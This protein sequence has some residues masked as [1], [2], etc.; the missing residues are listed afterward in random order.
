MSLVACITGL[1]PP[2]LNSGATLSVFA[3]TALA[4]ASIAIV[5]IVWVGVS[6]HGDQPA[7]SIVAT[8]RLVGVGLGVSNLLPIGSD[9]LLIGSG[10]FGN[11]VNISI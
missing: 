3:A 5:G 11:G 2:S 1:S 10:K 9:S 4:D 7:G 6:G 8:D